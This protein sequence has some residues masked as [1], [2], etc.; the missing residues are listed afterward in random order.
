MNEIQRFKS[1][2]TGGTAYT[3]P[4]DSSDSPKDPESDTASRDAATFASLYRTEQSRAN[5]LEALLGKTEDTYSE[6]L[7]GM[8]A[9]ASE[10]R[11]SL[12]F[13]DAHVPQWERII[14][15]HQQE[16]ERLRL[17]CHENG[18]RATEE[19]DARMSLQAQYDQA[20]E[21]W[22]RNDEQVLADSAALAEKTE[23]LSE[24]CRLTVREAAAVRGERDRLLRDAAPAREKLM[25]LVGGNWTVEPSLNDLATYAARFWGDDRKELERLR[26]EVSRLR[27]GEALAVGTSAKDGADRG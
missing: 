5:E 11:R 22:G 20:V 10:L 25:E 3:R 15:E 8:A 19:F 13:A 9:R 21:D 26:A 4:S 24:A 2:P 16:I 23:W 17:R 14:S 12:K 27:A 7:R 6:L 18:V 1:F